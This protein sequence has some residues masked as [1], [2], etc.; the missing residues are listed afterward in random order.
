M[1][2][3]QLESLAVGGQLLGQA[4]QNQATTFQRQAQQRA[5][6]LEARSQDLQNTMQQRDL[7]SQAE[8]YRRLNESREKMQTKELEQQASQFQQS[9]AQDRDLAL[10]DQQFAAAIA[11]SKSKAAQAA[12]Q[13]AAAQR[14]D[15]ELQKYRQAR[16]AHQENAL[17][18]EQA[19]NAARE[20][21]SL[22][23][24]VKTARIE[25]IDARITAYQDGQL[26]LNKTS[27]DAIGNAISDAILE[28][29]R[30]SGGFAEEVGR[31]ADAEVG[32][33][34]GEEFL[35]EQV[36]I[37]ART[38]LATPFVFLQNIADATFG[39]NDVESIRNRM[40]SFERSPTE[41]V[42]R[43]VD[44]AFSKYDDAFGVN[45]QEKAATQALMQS[46]IVS[47]AVLGNVR[48]DLLVLPPVRDSRMIEM[49][50][51]K[52]AETIGK[53]RQNGMQDSQI[54]GMLQA[55]EAMAER[56]ST[57]VTEEGLG[58]SGI[59]GAKG[60]VLEE[61]LRGVGDI[62]DGVESVLTDEKLM[63]QYGGGELVDYVKFNAPEVHRRAVQAWAMD[64]PQLQ[65]FK[66]EAKKL[67]LRDEKELA[68]IVSLLVE[69]DPELQRMG[70]SLDPQEIASMV[71]QM[72]R[73]SSAMALGA[74]DL[75]E[76]EGLAVQRFGAGAAA[77]GEQFN[78]DAL[79]QMIQEIRSQRGG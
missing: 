25:E 79:E 17:R 22:A 2:N 31:F 8:N 73:D 70:F 32:S 49:N 60:A 39:F 20:A 55:L 75:V 26:M 67:G 64:Q 53:L 74:Q 15:P 54:L 27:R 19:L 72:E 3:A 50:K 51:Q 61:T 37:V 35:P 1:P 29:T 68:G 34:P 71:L 66:E 36:G 40:T 52:V 14:D 76:R 12:A 10:M 47:G 9:Q 57:I 7:Q 21:K 33:I 48:D 28:N 77:Q 4:Q 78:I 46:L 45:P 6:G 69:N 16:R 43:V 44:H 42:S 63:R 62:I 24:T 59:Q 18:L 65:Q 56:S 5:A 58:T 41:F 38:N 23:Q 30:R 11:L 13:A